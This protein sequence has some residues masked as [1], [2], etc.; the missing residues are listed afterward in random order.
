MRV[1]V[2]LMRR[3]GVR[4]DWRDIINGPVFE[5]DILSDSLQGHFY[6]RLHDPQKPI[7]PD[8]LPISFGF[9]SNVA[10]R[11]SSSSTSTIRACAEIACM[12]VAA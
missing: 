5:G 2:K 12:M 7:A 10:T 8:L 9:P 11:F 3:R 6:V 4:P 1:R